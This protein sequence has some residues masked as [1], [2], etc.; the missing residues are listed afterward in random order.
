MTLLLDKLP[1]LNWKQP[2]VSIFPELLTH[3]FMFVVRD[4]G[5]SESPNGINIR[6]MKRIRKARFTLAAV[7]QRWREVA[8]ST[9]A[10]W[11][12]IL[13]P[14]SRISFNIDLFMYE[15]GRSG[16]SLLSLYIA[17]LPGSLH[18][19]REG[20][21]VSTLVTPRE[22]MII[23]TQNP[24]LEAFLWS[25]LQTAP[26]EPLQNQFLPMPHLRQLALSGK[27]ALSTVSFFDAPNL[28]VLE[29]LYQGRNQSEA[30][31]FPFPPLKD[32]FF[33]DLRVLHIG[34]HTDTLQTNDAA[35]IS[36]LCVHSSLQ[37]FSLS[38][39]IT[40]ALAEVL[41][42]L[43]SLLHVAAKGTYAKPPLRKWCAKKVS[44]LSWVSPTL[45]IHDLYHPN[46]WALD[47]FKKDPELLMFAR[48]I[49]VDRPVYRGQ[50]GA[51]YWDD[52]LSTMAGM[53]TRR[54]QDSML[55][56]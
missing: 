46:V 19:P 43:P 39:D 17:D 26:S 18:T 54:V 52:L 45:Y 31:L 23:V 16:N 6:D 1:A 42:A 55:E 34:G 12:T 32:I 3:I 50:V 2:A 20:T 7:C 40:E 35:I 21:R 8:I 53:Y 15:L 47:K 41:S 56:L 30:P 14:Y 29:L 28:T 51:T 44:V 49:W 9:P 33:P 5:E 37:V 11:S 10:L 4:W 24:S 25:T 13:L 36:F 22:I 27:I 48:Q 38:G